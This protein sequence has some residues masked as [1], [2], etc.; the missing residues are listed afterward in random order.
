MPALAH[1][2]DVKLSE[3]IRESIGIVGFE[4]FTILGAKADSITGGMGSKFAEAGNLGFKKTGVGQAA[5]RQSRMIGEE[6]GRVHGARLKSANN[7]AAAL[8][9]FDRMWAED[10]EGIGIASGQQ[11]AQR[12]AES[13]G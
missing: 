8:G 6:H 3:Q 11:S 4:L 9:R 2:I 10:G 12:L 13:F 7:P 5:H 1:E